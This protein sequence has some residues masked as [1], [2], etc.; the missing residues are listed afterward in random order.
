M[1][2]PTKK[3]YYNRCHASEALSPDDERNLDIDNFD[4]TRVRGSNWVSRLA[5]A[6]ELSERPVFLLF[7]GLPGSGKSTELRRLAQRLQDAQG[8]HLLPVLIDGDTSLD[9]TNEIDIPDIIAAIM[10]G[11]EQA[12][13]KIEGSDPA[14]ALEEGYFT[15][16]WTWLKTTEVELAKAEFAIPGNGSKLVAE[17]RG[18]PT[19]RQRVRATL[20]THLSSFLEEAREELEQLEKRAREHGYQGLVIIF[21]SLE[22][23]RGSSQNWVGVLASAERIFSSGAPYLKLPVH[24]LYTVPTAL[25]NRQ[26]FQD[27][28][29]IP[30][31]KLHEPDGRPWEAGYAAA[32]ELVRRRLPDAIAREIFGD[33]LEARLKDVIRWSGGYPRE[34]VRLLQ[35]ALAREKLPLSENEFLR[36]FNELKD[37]YRKVVPA[38]AFAWLANV[39]TER[40][41]TV[42]EEK[43]RQIADQMLLNNVV[44]RYVNDNDW[45]DLHP[46]VA[47]I[48]GVR[49]ALSQTRNAAAPPA[50][51]DAA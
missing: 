2:L 5:S 36:I 3:Y 48:P 21:D 17:M 6:I 10:L 7:T 42:E 14:T 29:F 51:P 24:V 22:K 33:M 8:A 9:L 26:L 50:T 12:V 19:L 4:D 25:I 43:H 34:L 46:A 32:R 37:A 15:R 49:Q 47:E 45:Y 13:L 41:Y 40:Y 35:S 28:H 38:D 1:D 44:L 20:G 31:I 18:R 16:L 30:M 11:V 39:A 23:L 27:V